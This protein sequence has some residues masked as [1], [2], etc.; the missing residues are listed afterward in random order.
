M[1]GGSAKRKSQGRA[2]RVNLKLAMHRL[3]FPVPSAVTSSASSPGRRR[4]SPE[5][6]F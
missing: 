2:A 4:R 1:A 5:L 3:L 6:T